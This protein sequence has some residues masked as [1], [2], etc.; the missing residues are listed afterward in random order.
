MRGNKIVIAGALAVHLCYV[1][2]EL[3]MDKLCPDFD[4]IARF[5]FEL[6]YPGVRIII[7]RTADERHLQLLV[8]AHG[9]KPPFGSFL[10][11][12]C[13]VTI[14]PERLQLAREAAGLPSG[15]R[16]YRSCVRG[17]GGREWN[18]PSTGRQQPGQKLKGLEWPHP[19]QRIQRDQRDQG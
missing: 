1:F 18:Y 7:H 12:T 19:I 9:K 11:A 5:R 4:L 14:G 15:R 10:P 8:W 3:R 17:M 16:G 6:P 2:I 13:S